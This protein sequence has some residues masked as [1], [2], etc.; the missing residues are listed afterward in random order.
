MSKEQHPVIQIVS[1]LH[2]C[3]REELEMVQYHVNWLVEDKR[4]RERV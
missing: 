3:T 1:L 2:D 4:K